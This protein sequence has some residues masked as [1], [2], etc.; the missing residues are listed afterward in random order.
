MKFEIKS[1]HRQGKICP[2]SQSTISWAQKLG[3]WRQTLQFDGQIGFHEQ[4]VQQMFFFHLLMFSLRI[5]VYQSWQS[6]LSCQNFQKLVGFS[7][8]VIH[9][10]LQGS[11]LVFLRTAPTEKWKPKRALAERQ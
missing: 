8:R 1:S 2:L 11:F 7:L 6:Q 4:T 3:Y 10:H 5:V 9:L